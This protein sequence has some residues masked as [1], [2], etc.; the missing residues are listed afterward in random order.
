[1]H[2]SGTP[3]TAIR[4]QP[5]GGFRWPDLYVKVDSYLDKKKVGEGIAKVRLDAAARA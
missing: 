3:G 1:M 5:S 2:P 4:T